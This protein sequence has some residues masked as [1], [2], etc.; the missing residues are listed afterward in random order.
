M[1]NDNERINRLTEENEKLKRELDALKRELEKANGTS[2]IF[3]SKDKYLEEFEKQS[4]SEILYSRKSYTSFLI[5]HISNTS[6]FHVYKRIIAFLK[7]YTL[8]STTLKI[9]AVILAVLQTSTVFVLATSVFVVSLPFTFLVGYTALLLSLFGRRKLKKRIKELAASKDIFILTPPRG[10]A[11]E[12]GSF[13]RGM[14]E[15]IASD[16]EKLVIIISPFFFSSKGVGESKKP[17]FM[18]RI[19]SENVIIVRRHYY[20]SLKRSRRKNTDE[21]NDVTI[22]Y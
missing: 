13:F 7:K 15:D 17:F 10:R 6:V 19:E 21:K 8:I 20:F 11:F 9:A 18:A 3:S 4:R 22:L 5:S 16:K 2:P 12:R 14:A 1:K